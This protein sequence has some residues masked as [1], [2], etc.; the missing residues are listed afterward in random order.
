MRCRSHFRLPRPPFAPHALALACLLGLWPAA[1]AATYTVSTEAELRQ[2]ILDLNAASGAH[3]IDLRANIALTQ[4]LPPITN[5]LSFRG[6]GFQLDG[7]SQYQLLVLGDPSGAGPRILVQVS[8]LTL[9]NGLAAG[10]DGSSGGG[11]GLGAGGAL[12][13]SSRADVLLSNVDVQDSQALGGNGAAGLGGSGGMLDGLSGA[14]YGAGGDSSAG[15]TGSAGSWGGGGGSGATG[16]G[17]GGVAGGAGGST[18]GGGGGGLGGGIFV[19]DGGSLSLSGNS[20]LLGNAAVGGS[21]GGDGSAGSA[22]GSSMFLAGSG[23]LILRVSPTQT[24]VVNDSISDSVGAGLL[25]A[26]SYAQWNVLVAGGGPRPVDPG[27]PAQGQ[28]YGKVMLDGANLFSGN[29][30]VDGADVVVSNLD[31]LGVGSGVVALND[32]GLYLSSGLTL[33]RD[34]AV[35]N[36]GGRIGVTSGQVV[37]AND[38][39]GTGTMEKVGAGNLVLAGTSSHTGDW[40]ISAG[41][42]V[43]DSDARLGNAALELFGGGILFSAAFNDLRSIDLGLNGTINNGGFDVTLN[44]VTNWGLSGAFRKTLI[45]EGSGTTTLAGVQGGN[46]DTRVVAGT[47]VGAIATGVLTVEAGATYGLGGAD[48]TVGALAGGGDVVL[49][50]NRLAIALESGDDA[51]VGA[52]TGVIS[53]TGSLTIGPQGLPAAFDPLVDVSDYNVQALGS[54][55]TYSGGT[56]VYTGVVLQIADDTAV[57]GGPLRLAGGVLRSDQASSDLNL[58]LMGGGGILGDLLLNGVVSGVGT[59]VKYGPGTLTLANANTYVGN[60][61]V[62]GEGAYLELAHPAALGSGNLQL[63]QGGG[64]RLLTDTASLRPVQILDGVGVV[65]VGSFDVQSLGGITGAAP[66]STLR[67]EGSGRLLLTG[68]LTLGGGVDIAAGVLQVGNGGSAG[69]VSG[70]VSIASGAQLVIDRSGMLTLASNISGGGSVTVSGT[71]AVILAP[72][73]ANTFLG[74]LT[75]RNGIV[76]ADSER[77]LGF[78]S[79]LLDDFGGLHLLGDINRT[80]NIGSVGGRL[81]VGSGDSFTLGGDVLQAGGLLAKTG[82]GTLVLAGVAGEGGATRV[83][84]GTLQVGSGLRGNL[85]GDVLVDAGATLVFGRDDL[86]QYSH[87]IDGD[88]SVIK[89]GSGDLVLTADQLFAGTFFVEAGNLR[90]GL[91]GAAGSLNGDVDLAA[92]TRLLFDRGDASV[93]DGDT[94]GA[95]ALQKIG[96]GLLTVLGDLGHGGGTTV[97]SGELAIGDGGTAG[98]IAGDVSLALGTRLVINRGDEVALAANLAGTGLLVQRGTGTTVL[99]GSNTQS[100][101]VIIEGGRLGVDSDA[102]LGGGDLIL[103][104][105]LLRY[106]AAFDDLRA[107]RLRS[108]GGG[109]DSNGF[110]VAYAGQVSGNGLFTKAGAGRLTVTSLLGVN[111]QVDAGELRIGDGATAGLLAGNA[112][113]AAGATLA[114]DRGDLVS[115]GAGLAGSGDLRQLGSGELRLPGNYAAFVG[116]AW[117][118]DG[119]LRLDGVLGGDLTLADGTLLQGSGSVLGNLDLGAARFTPGNSLDSFAVGGNLTLGAG[120]ETVIEVDAA[121]NAD[122]ISVGGTA[123]LDGVLKVLPQPG[124]YTAAGCC[125]YTVLTAA[126]VNGS[127]ASVSN[128]L[129]FL[130]TQ[131]SYLP[132]SVQLDFARNTVAFTTVSLTWNQQQVSAAIDAM[133]AADPADALAALVAP[134]NATQA[135]RAFDGLSGDTLLVAVDASAH[136]AAR[137]TQLLSRRGSRLGLASRGG[138]PGATLADLNVLRHGGM[139]AAPQREDDVGFRYNGPTSP[140]EGVWVEATA[141]DMSEK[142]DRDVGSADGRLSGQLLALGVDGYWRDALLVGFAAGTLEGDLAYDNRSAQGTASATFAGLYGRWDSGAGLQYKAA[143]S[144]AQQDNE[145]RRTVPLGTPSLQPQGTLGVTTLGLALEAGLAMHVASVG[146]RPHVLLDVQ[147]LEQDAYRETAGGSAALEADASSALLGDFG[148]GLEVSRPWLTGSERWAQVS[149]SLA[150]L[151]P[152]GDTQREQTVNFTGAGTPFT[153]RGTPD[154]SAVLALSLGGEVYLTSQLALWGGAESRVSGAYTELNGVLSMQYR[155]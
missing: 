68:A 114:F 135:R 143:L 131:V 111:V 3:F 39:S 55:N 50:G 126:A 54:G 101:G 150:L 75:V 52:F 141:I 154:D 18:G 112:T 123:T 6:N 89:R 99:V 64:L 95:G 8:N 51:P 61:L 34:M 146:L 5:T 58:Q 65:D 32:G 91:G 153:V 42:L 110:D 67:K 155:W 145:M 57:G 107:L 60:T 70:N 20:A 77:G 147:A 56:T 80:V 102:R 12:L 116:H 148:V 15:G 127:F 63:S 94:T 138:E 9:S 108:G 83:V 46:G 4:S 11:G 87:V 38:I 142:A 31:A 151:Q 136:T 69:G 134:L 73:E 17:S 129:V 137:F 124:D 16:G 140:V 113:V 119:S 132:T 82:A 115:L 152:F 53:G 10:G 40:R 98:S 144:L 2:A 104:G 78:G 48:R 43:L 103:D 84:E 62:Y 23:N 29:L 85:A 79:V 44:G 13:V 133:E 122:H 41:K 7:Q 81:A 27:N 76:A 128:D 21:G 120:S 105:G 25:P 74:G 97:T 96:P 30:Y 49:G 1:Q 36:D 59:L 47:V 90:V 130:D 33:A 35:D 22:A 28:F 19:A 92:G 118:D 117:V 109:L 106:E 71:G 24:L 86:V 26:S 72:T 66:D 37:L 100:G 121:G 139:P 14:S 149:G 93:F 125:S 45:F 88:G